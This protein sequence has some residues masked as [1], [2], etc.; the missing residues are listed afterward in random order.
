M[1]FFLRWFGAFVLL[2]ATYN[3]TEWSFLRWAWHNHDGQLPLTVLLGLLLVIGYILYW[4]YAIRA[5]G[6]FALLL[7]GCVFA[8]TVWVLVDWGILTAGTADARLW[9]GLGALSLVLGT[10][11]TLAALGASHHYPED[12]YYDD[13]D[14]T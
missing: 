9:G 3:P 7:T 6:V 14:E 1:G 12:D 4:N 10:G 8:A 13:D 11:L 2:A 5:A